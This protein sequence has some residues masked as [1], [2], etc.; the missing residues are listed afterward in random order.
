MAAFHKF[1]AFVDALVKKKI[2]LV[3]DV[4]KLMLTATLPVAANSV[5]A[6]VSATELAAGNGYSTG[7][8]A[9]GASGVSNVAGTEYLIGNAVV[10]T[11]TPGA[12][13]PFEYVIL[14][15]FSATNK[16]LIAWF[17]YGSA[18]TLGVNETFTV[19][20]SNNGNWTTSYPILT[21]A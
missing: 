5:Y 21:L 12:M 14:Y 3:N 6:D 4:L 2:D 16:D 10:F 15:D 20:S 11:A 19:N 17:D 1:N 9:I 13:G 18:I 8:T 7:G